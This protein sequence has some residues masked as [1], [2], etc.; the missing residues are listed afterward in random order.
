MNGSWIRLRFQGLC[1]DTLYEISYSTEPDVPVDPSLA[2]AYG[3][4]IDAH[5]HKTYQAYGTELMY[6]GI[7]INRDTL[8]K[9]SMDFSSLLFVIKQIE[10]A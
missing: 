5:P 10:E 4:R 7:P 3:I 9:K 8:N 6:A 2:A 1:E